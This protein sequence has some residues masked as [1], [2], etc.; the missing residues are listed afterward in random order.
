MKFENYSSTFKLTGAEI[1][2]LSER[3]E[4]ALVSAGIERQNR[5]RI[6]LSTEEA[7]LRMRDRFGEDQYVDGSIT[8]RFGKLLI[9]IDL[10]GEQYN[11]LSEE[12][13]ELEDVCGTLLTAIGLSPQYQ[14]DGR[15]NSFRIQIPLPGMN[16]AIKILFAIAGGVILGLI[17]RALFSADTMAILDPGLIEPMI[18]LWNRI[19]NVISGPVI[20][21]IV[22][23]AT[24]NAGRLSLSGI[25]YKKVGLRY[26][27]IS[28]LLASITAAV[29]CIAFRMSPG[30]MPNAEQTMGV[31]EGML[32]LVPEDFVT[33]FITSNTPQLLLMAIVLGIAL[34]VLNAQTPNLTRVVKQINAVGLQLAEW[35]SRIVPYVTLLFIGFEIWRKRTE[36]LQ[37]LWHCLLI[38]VLISVSFMLAGV[39]L[40]A[41]KEKMSPK[42]LFSKLWPSFLL[43]LST[44]SLD[45]AFG[46]VESSCTKNLGMQRSFVSIALPNGLILYMPISAVGTVVFL[47]YL[48]IQFK[49]EVSL[50]YLVLIVALA[51]ILFVASPPVPGANLLAYIM[52]F[53]TLG[54]PQDALVGAMVFDIVFGFFADSANQMMLQLELILQGDKMGLLDKDILKKA[55]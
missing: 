44:G 51:V 26:F 37:G 8:K 3:I 36:I 54:F 18:S 35:L 49:V 4:D 47:M 50:I 13:A 34:N 19:L 22:I 6:R 28:Y 14:F 10:E 24:L 41:S 20:F 29:Y 32:R 42:L 46:K 16:P 23:T 1:D 55:G 31:I 15:K 30:A 33:P 52:M 38:S 9:R 53:Q 48:T 21:F 17:G 11:P 43:S 2:D 39:L 40:T 12:E 25:D 27:L 5:F 45:V 7:L